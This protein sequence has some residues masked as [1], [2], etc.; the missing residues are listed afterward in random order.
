MDLAINHP[1]DV[2]KLQ[3]KRHS[4]VRSSPKIWAK[5]GVSDPGSIR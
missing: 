1:A 3:A 4:V 5:I 2:T